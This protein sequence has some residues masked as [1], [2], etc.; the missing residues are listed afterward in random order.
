MHMRKSGLS[1]SDKVAKSQALSHLATL[2]GRTSRPDPGSI[3]HYLLGQL[4][5]NYCVYWAREHYS[6]IK[7]H[8][9]LK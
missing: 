1:V 4:C 7:I 6:V 9:S 2:L 3:I 8:A 5:Q